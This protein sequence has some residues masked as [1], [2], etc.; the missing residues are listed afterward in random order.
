MKAQK[1]IVILGAG[2]W[3]TALALLLA[4]NGQSVWLWGHRQQELEKLD[5][6]RCNSRYLPGYAFPDNL[7]L[8]LNLPSLLATVRDVLVVV[9]SHCFRQTLEQIQS[10]HHHPNLR[11]AFA[12]KGLDP[13]SRQLLHQVAKEILGPNVPLLI[14]SGPSFASEVAA[15][16]PTAITVASVDK[17]FA[18]DICE[19]LTNPRFRTY[20]S[21][22]LIG[23]QLA[24]A[25][26]NVMAIASGISDG[27]GFG[28]N[29]RSAL[30]T[31][32]LAEMVRLGLALGGQ[33]ETFM[34]LAGVGDLILTCTDNQSRNRRFGIAL[35][36]GQSTNTA[37]RDI[38]Q[39]V[40]GIQATEQVYLL[41]KELGIEMPIT[42]TV[43]Q[44]L[45][46][47]LGIKDAVGQLFSRPMKAEGE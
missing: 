33:L 9:P 37:C 44:V 11:L 28:A 32:G 4:R 45:Q 40:E 13:H 21:D 7:Q 2:S 41:A 20:T 46:G 22:D 29:A 18:S 3:G 10:V 16:L 47:T 36:Q 5:A 35:G 19:R 15:N 34:G 26:K 30:I 27:L 43:Y 1:P 31:R 38:G 23:V 8:A 42:D 17:L 6:E 39:V 24:G 12:T 25:S 14:I